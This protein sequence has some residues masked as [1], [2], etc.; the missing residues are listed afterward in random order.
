MIKL[1]T[2]Q[3]EIGDELLDY[4]YLTQ[5]KLKRYLMWITDARV[6]K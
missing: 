4:V 6:E 3:F 1:A 5:F 2:K